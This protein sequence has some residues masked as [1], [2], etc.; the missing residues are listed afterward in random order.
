MS[1]TSTPGLIGDTPSVRG[2]GSERPRMQK[3]VPR[4][5]NSGRCW[6]AQSR[7]FVVSVSE[8]SKIQLID[9]VIYWHSWCGPTRLFQL[10]FK[11]AGIMF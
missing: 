9:H 2:D 11:E 3:R 6:A 4:A 10:Q 1:W 8:F 7:D 5:T